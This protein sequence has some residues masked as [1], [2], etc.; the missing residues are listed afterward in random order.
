[1]SSVSTVSTAAA[2]AAPA[3]PAI[4]P[5]DKSRIDR[6]FS[7]IVALLHDASGDGSSRSRDLR[8]AAE[9]SQFVHYPA[10]RL[11]R[12]FNFLGRI[13]PAE[14]KSQ[15]A[16]DCIVG[17]AQCPQYVAGLG[18]G[19]GARAAGAYGHV[20]HVHQQRLAIDIGEADVQV[21]CKA[22]RGKGG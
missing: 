11:D 17:Q 18:I 4:P 22:A 14:T 20:L 5:E 1:M 16:A 9:F 10:D 15:A 19:A 7:E 8:Q 21:S 6:I 2:P 12:E 13:E 3:V